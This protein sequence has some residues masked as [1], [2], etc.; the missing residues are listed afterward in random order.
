MKKSLIGA[1]VGALILFIW[2]FLSFAMINF[3]RPAQDFT[4]K[5]D[6]ILN[7]LKTQNLKDGGYVLPNLPEGAGMEESEKIMET[8]KGQPWAVLQYHNAYEV[9]MTMN[10]I[11]GLLV[12]LVIM[13]LF[14]WIVRKFS[15][16]TT[17]NILTASL[18]TGLI[19]FLYQPYIGHIW[20]QTFDIWAYFLDAIVSW[21][22]AGLWLA[23]WLRRGVDNNTRYRATEGPHQAA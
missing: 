14:I 1:F 16:P 3:H 7:F 4:E 23:W 15:W 18:F 8:W 17:G 20:F 22:L 12:N 13:L 11:R 5:Q 21:G 2:Q 10:M 9:D 6:V 19:T